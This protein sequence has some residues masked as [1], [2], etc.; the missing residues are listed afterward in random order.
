LLAVAA[1]LAA[2]GLWAGMVALDRY[3][4]PF[5]DRPFDPAVWAAADSHDRG[6]MARDAIRHLPFGTPAARVRE[7][8]RA[9]EPLPGVPGSPVDGFGH[10]LEHPEK[11][12]YYLGSWSA[13][14][15]YGID[16]AFLYVH[17]GTDGRVDSMGKIAAH[18]LKSTRGWCFLD[19]SV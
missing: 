6:P 7:L 12:S 2:G 19:I 18:L 10:R 3:L 13:L 14:G 16:D 4:D 8:L 1:L 9:P 15:P 11:W 5:D 17:F